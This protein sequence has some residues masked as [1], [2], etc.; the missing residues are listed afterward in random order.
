MPG[1][2]E[3]TYIHIPTLHEVYGQDGYGWY[4]DKETADSLFEGVELTQ[5]KNP[6][7]YYLKDMTAKKIRNRGFVK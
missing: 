3:K 7:W 5:S 4:C 2:N 6:L 1:Y